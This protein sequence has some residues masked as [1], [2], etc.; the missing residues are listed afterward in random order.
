MI[1][2]YFKYNLSSLLNYVRYYSDALVLHMLSWLTC[3]TCLSFITCSR[4]PCAP[5]R[6]VHCALRALIPYVPCALRVLIRP[7]TSV[8]GAFAAH[9]PRA[10]HAPVPYV[11]CA[12][13]VLLLHVL[14]CLTWLVPYGLS[15]LICFAPYVLSYITCYVPCVLSC[16]TCVTCSCTSRVFYSLSF[17]YFRCFKPNMIVWIS[18]LVASMS[19]VRCTFVAWVIQFFYRLN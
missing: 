2:L 18:Y 12:P 19:C 8:L 3:I 4:N 10:L 9:L 1:Q 13:R 11:F 5:V 16:V 6:H 17:T 15:C 7:V 14:S